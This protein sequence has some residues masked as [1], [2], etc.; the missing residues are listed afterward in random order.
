MS[1]G[2]LIRQPGG[3][4]NDWQSALDGFE[5][6]LQTSERRP[7][8]VENYML[9][10]RWFADA[11]SAG[12][13]EVSTRW[14]EEWLNGHNWSIHTRRRVL[15]SLRHFYAWGIGAHL[16]QRS[17]LVG[18]SGSTA[19]QTGPARIE[20]SDLW[21]EPLRSFEMMLH[22]GGRSTATIRLY[23][24]RLIGLSHNFADPWTV[25]MTDL[26]DFLSR[27]D[28]A[29]D[30]KKNARTAIRRFYSWAVDAGF[31]DSSPAARLDPVRVARALP[32]PASTESIMVA[33]KSL[34]G[35][36]RLA[37]DLC[38]FA[39]LRIGE[40]VQVQVHDILNDQLLVHGKGGRERLVPLH[41]ELRTALRA[42]LSRRAD[43]GINS[44]WLFPSPAPQRVGN[45]RTAGN[46][47]KRLSEALGPAT[48]AHM[49]R[50]R[51]ATQAYGATRDLRAVQELLG[52]S[53]P[54]TTARYAAVPDGALTASVAGV[55]LL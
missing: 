21:G 10:V 8:T 16:C 39:G 2:V 15:Q 26:S 30:T 41:P 46:L 25:T 38:M 29:G 7:S 1:A 54:S 43:W 40:V 42:E 19:Q 4:M 20:P 28:W 23:R 53:L 6:N 17:P 11:S 32:R 55:G 14:L 31:I 44:P 3:T 49:L 37:L 24:M 13:W 33:R 9:Y 27:P 50:H 12:P 47:G 45:H 52:H 36:G 18:V 35:W 34:D 5:S 51:F 22:A 48:T